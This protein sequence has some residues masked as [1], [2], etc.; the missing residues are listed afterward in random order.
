LLF[1]LPLQWGGCLLQL[2]LP[3]Q[4]G[5]CLLALSSPLQ[6]TGTLLQIAGAHLKL[7]STLLVLRSCHRNSRLGFLYAR[8]C[9][10]YR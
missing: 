9:F 4:R 2:G 8:S 6:R 7:L 1:G 5:D 10:D 3:L